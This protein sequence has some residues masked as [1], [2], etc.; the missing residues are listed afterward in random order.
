MNSRRSKTA[1]IFTFLIEVSPPA[2]VRVLNSTGHEKF[3]TNTVP[4]V[5]RHI[6][7]SVDDAVYA[8]NIPAGLFADADLERTAYK[9][10]FAHGERPARQ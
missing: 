4:C 1:F 7:S 10:A 3:F 5:P 9:Q 8:E 2:A 6:D